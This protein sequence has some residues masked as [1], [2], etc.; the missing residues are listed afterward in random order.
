[1][2]SWRPTYDENGNPIVTG[3]D[4]GILGSGIPNPLVQTGKGLVNGAVG[5]YNSTQ[6]PDPQKVGDTPAG[7]QATSFAA[8]LIGAQ[9]GLGTPTYGTAPNIPVGARP[10]A[11]GADIYSQARQE[12]ASVPQGYGDLAAGVN[13]MS[14]GLAQRLTGGAV[15]SPYNVGGTAIRQQNAGIQDAKR[16]VAEYEKSAAAWDQIYGGQAKQSGYEARATTFNA[17]QNDFR[18]GMTAPQA[19]A[20]QIT[21]AAPQVRFNPL[22]GRY[23][24]QAPAAINAQ[25]VRAD[26]IGDQQMRAPNDIA[27]DGDMRQAQM[28]A[29][30]YYEDAALGRVPSAAEA[31]M[32]KGIDENVGAQLG[33]AATLQGNTPGLALRAGLA[34]AQGAVARSAADMAA[35]RA[36]EQATARAGFLQAATGIRSQDIQIAQSNQTK[37][38]TTAVT[39]LNARIEVLKSNQQ[40]ALQAGMANQAANLQSQI[41]NASNQL[42]AAKASAANSLTRDI[43]NLTAQLD[44]SKANA[45]NQVSQNIANL[46]SATQITQANLNAA[47][48][49]GLAQEAARLQSQLANQ[50]AQLATQQANQQALLDEAKINAQTS[51]ENAR[52]AQNQQQFNS[53]S[54]LSAQQANQNAGLTQQQINNNLYNGLTN[55][56][57]QAIGTTLGVT[58]ADIGRQSAVDAANAGANLGLLTGGLRGAANLAFSGGSGAPAPVPQPYQYRSTGF[59]P[60]GPGATNPDDYIG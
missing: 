2:A 3:T 40:A 57:N 30:G 49:T 4:G 42:E 60:G 44:A 14:A 54:A 13:N 23:G 7:Q 8:G 15:S 34:G 53:A 20:P 48:Q 41:H 1:M 26:M 25:Q 22:T 17:P 10:T 12:L 21:S 6:T 5:L 59:V 24:V 11:P 50:Q 31:L 18:F 51:M 28:R 35:L 47:L 39:N 52:L 36:D 46:Q 37:D 27:T 45:A 19:G 9:Q 43:A 38:L 33:M 56:A 16:Q 55:N 58:S 32:R 29:L